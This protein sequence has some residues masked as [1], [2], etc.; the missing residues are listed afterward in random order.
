MKKYGWIITLIIP[1]ALICGFIYFNETE[2]AN[3]KADNTQATAEPTAQVVETQ[4]VTPSP[5]A[6]KSSSSIISTVEDEDIGDIGKVIFEGSAAIIGNNLIV[7]ENGSIWLRDSSFCTASELT[8]NIETDKLL[9]SSNA[10][11]IKLVSSDY[12]YFSTA[13]G[14]FR[15]S[16]SMGGTAR[17]SEFVP[18]G[19]VL[20]HSNRL[21]YI[22]GSS[23]AKMNTISM[24][25]Y[26]GDCK[27]IYS[28]CDL[29]AA[30]DS[31][32]YVD[33]NGI[34]LLSYDGKTLCR[35]ES[36]SQIQLVD[37]GILYVS[38][39]EN[40]VRFVDFADGSL[41]TR[42]TCSEGV[43]PSIDMVGNNDGY[44]F[45]T[46][47]VH[48]IPR[49]VRTA[50]SASD[51]TDSYAAIRRNAIFVCC[52]GDSICIGAP[53]SQVNDNTL[54]N[55]VFISPD[56]TENQIGSVDGIVN[57][58]LISDSM[59]LVIGANNVLT[60]ISIPIA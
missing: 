35:Y 37:N 26:G 2:G 54:I 29:I 14:L 60:C 55:L 7:L 6:T 19:N 22:Y 13:N 12:L 34:K 16:F 47:L 23:V 42:F 46:L 44:T 21:Y 3:I 58:F 31:G 59:L 28:D 45:F 53:A 40:A 52:I 50:E 4:T 5:E 24:T 8:Y 38:D 15:Y 18:I 20:I 41:S 56:G 25:T 36:A 51:G 27:S 1:I 17:V 57:A 48:D 49:V 11:S 32:L 43:Y 9:V 10:Q 33:D 30:C 39:S